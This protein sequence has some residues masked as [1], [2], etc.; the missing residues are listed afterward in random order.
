[1]KKKSQ[2]NASPDSWYALEGKNQDVV[3]STRASLVRN[4]ANF[5][6]PSILDENE[7]ER[8]QSIAFDAFTFL[9]DAQDFH[10]ISVDRLDET[11]LRIMKER[12]VLL[13]QYE[14]KKAGIILRND[15]KI[16]CSVNTYDHLLLSSFN[17]GSAIDEAA[18]SV[19]DLD[20]ELQGH[21]QFA[22]SYDFGYLS[23]SIL[24]SG[25][26]LLLGAKFHL[27]AIS[28]LDR[29]SETIRNDCSTAYNFT[30]CYGAG[31]GDS[32]SG[33]AGSGTSLGA[34]Y[35]VT[36]LTCAG[37]N[38]LEQI[39]SMKEIIDKIIK[40]ERLA[41]KECK[42]LHLTKIK[43]Y[44]SR[45]V[46]LAR[47]SYFVSLRESIDIIGGVKFGYDMGVISGI[48]DQ[49]L[50]CL[51]YRVQEGHLEYLLANG[52]FKFEKDILDNKDL[53]IRRLRSLI[54]QEAFEKISQ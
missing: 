42:S 30:A 46:A 23:S 8:I 6:F 19:Y 32:V 26:G 31:G 17:S 34:Y 43:N 12:G 28:M 7:S 29:L 45:A 52:N 18:K 36:T 54:L 27:P 40:D 50:H 49:V 47:S 53:K 38:E 22:A 24:T 39:S 51:L 2:Q 48:D 14:G 16:S 21:V 13:P 15:G 20:H 3:L 44:A 9:P 5:P 25:T 10:T 35:L 11:G 33:V 4:L 41:R 1:M 37:G